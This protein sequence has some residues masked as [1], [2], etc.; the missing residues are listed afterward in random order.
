MEK[1]RTMVVNEGGQGPLQGAV[2]KRS[3]GFAAQKR[4]K[5]LCRRHSEGGSCIGRHKAPEFGESLPFAKNWRRGN[6]VKGC[7]S[8]SCTRLHVLAAWRQVQDGTCLF[9]MP[10]LLSSL[11]HLCL[12]GSF[13]RTVCL[14]G[15]FLMP[16][17]QLP[18]HSLCLQGSFLRTALIEE[19][20][21]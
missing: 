14:Q 5:K 6:W 10:C 7:S 1:C 15:S 21:G 19:G 3:E 8:L 4:R 9:V 20:Y 2:L 16:P 12:H 17:R 11:R 13:L 18:S